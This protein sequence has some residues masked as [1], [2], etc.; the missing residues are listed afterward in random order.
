MAS[1]LA[2]LG[3]PPDNGSRAWEDQSYFKLWKRDPHVTL[4]CHDS[5]EG[6]CP[7][8]RWS[9]PIQPRKTA[10]FDRLK[11][12]E[13]EKRSNW[14]CLLFTSD[15]SLFSLKFSYAYRAESRGPGVMSLLSF[16]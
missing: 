2:Q 14:D 5:V 16:S 7:F 13:G 15:R 8:A 3:L 4:R 9:R 10:S 11:E 12:E 6:Q 1:L